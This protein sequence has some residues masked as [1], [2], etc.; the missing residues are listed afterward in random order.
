TNGWSEDARLSVLIPAGKAPSYLNDILL[1]IWH[2]RSD[3]Q[4]LYPE[5]AK[6]DLTN[7]GRWATTKG[8][9]ED[10]RLS[11]IIRPGE[12]PKY[13]DNSLASIWKERSDLQKLYPEA[14]KG[15]L[16]NLDIW[17]TTKG[18]DEDKR[19]ALLIP[20]GKVPSYLSDILFSI[21]QGRNDLQALYP[22]V[23]NHNFDNI[24]KW[25][26]TTGWDQDNRLAVLIPQGKIPSYLNHVLLSIWHERSDLQKLYPEAAKGNLTGLNKWAITTGWDQDKRLGVLVPP[27]KIPSYTQAQPSDNQRSEERRVGKECRSR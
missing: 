11:V 8:W 27:G 10:S 19:L 6:G 3:L 7:L 21:W 16:T 20:A 1:S 24:K 18:W 2:E 5:A 12:V 15:N 13:L 26:T 4:K 22:E 9:N 23:V 17:A 25:A 14:A